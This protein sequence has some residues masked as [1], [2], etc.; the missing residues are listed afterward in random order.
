M[1]REKLILVIDDEP[2]VLEALSAV[3]TDNGYR[4]EGAAS[5]GEGLEKIEKINPDAVLLDIRMP[6]IDG[7]KVL[8]LVK[9]QGERTPIILI[10]AYGSTQTTI[11]AMKLGAFDYLMKP[12]KINDLLEVLKKAVEV[13]ELI[14]RARAGESTPLSDTDTMIGLSPLMQNVYKI[15]G[16]VT[17][18]NATVLIRGES[19]TGKELV[20]RAIHFN[21]VRRDRP[22]VKI[23]C[24]SIP[25]SLLESEL[26]GH[27]KGAF[28]GA[29]AAKPGKFELAHKGTIFLDEIGEMSLSTQTKLLRVLQEREFERVGGTETIKVDVRIIAATN[30]DLEKSIEEGHFR[31]DLY[32]R[33]NVVEIVIPPLRERKEDIPALVNHIIKGCSAE[34]KKTIKGFS[35]EAMEILLSYDWPGNIRELKNVCERAVLMSTGPVLGV[36]VLPL[37]LKKKSRRFSWLGEIPGGSLKEIVSEVEREIILRALE[38]HNWNRSAAAQ[39]LKMNR[40]SFYAKLKELGILD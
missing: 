36:E 5:G 3:L 18:T 2:G 11:E 21:S 31:E 38:E 20:A 26:F 37:T 28:T 33:L 8:E 22:F 15:I 9:R 35:P 19:G 39:A 4:V 29:V 40:S 7:L 17:N 32:Y 30:K 10:T 25:E 24:A 1:A 6:D 13:K 34:Y 12:L 27:E 14:E 16:R 23:N